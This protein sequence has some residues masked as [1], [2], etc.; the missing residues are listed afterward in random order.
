MTMQT[1]RPPDD[2]TPLLA[3]L[4]AVEPKPD[5][6]SSR[7]EKH[8]YASRLSRR[9]AVFAA[10]ALRREFPKILPTED[11]VG[12]ESVTGGSEG[13]KR[14]D[15]KAWDEVLGLELLVSIKTY[16][17]QDWDGR[18]RR[19]GRYTKNVKRN[20]FELM[21][22]A[23]VIHRRQP[24]SVMVGLLFLPDTACHDGDENAVG[25]RGASSFAS[26]VRRL[27]VRSGR[28][29]A[30]ENRGERGARSQSR[31]VPPS[32]RLDGHPGLGARTGA[33]G[34][35]Q[36][37]GSCSRSSLIDAQPLTLVPGP[38]GAHQRRE[39]QPRAAP[40]PWRALRRSSRAITC[41][42][43]SRSSWSL[44]RWVETRMPP[45]LDV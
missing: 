40:A 28:A 39:P 21:H 24:Y 4:D 15:V 29:L 34:R 44:Y 2:P 19:A 1:T 12:H 43:R 14:L 6:S 35:R 17:F 11:D 9:L 16:S 13:G 25:D 23:D 27:R 42:S 41:S 38:R 20:G 45:T 26:I 7:E 18:R 36:S 3:T 5:V 22:E 32:G 8:A 33:V 31:C 37:R 10:S 30:R